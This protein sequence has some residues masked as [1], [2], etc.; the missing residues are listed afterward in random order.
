MSSLNTYTTLSIHPSCM[1]NIS[2]RKK[3]RF[4]E[5]LQYYKYYLCLQSCDES[6]ARRRLCNRVGAER[7]SNG[8]VESDN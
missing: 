6:E 4:N 3:T 5:P 7:T 1:F 8:E 2:F